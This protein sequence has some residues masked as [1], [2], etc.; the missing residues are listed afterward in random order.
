MRKVS[1]GKLPL[2][3]SP[4]CKETCC[5]A[6]VPS[7]TSATGD[8]SLCT[9]L[10]CTDILVYWFHNIC[11]LC[12]LYSIIKA[13]CL[14]RMAIISCCG[15]N[16]SAMHSS[17][18]QKDWKEQYTE[19][20]Y[21]AK[22]KQ[23]MSVIQAWSQMLLHMWSTS[24]KN[25]SSFHLAKKSFIQ[26]LYICFGCIWVPIPLNEVCSFETSWKKSRQFLWIIV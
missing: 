9:D 25:A 3:Y 10:G 22:I 20:F 8:G 19:L 15:I 21:S 11:R 14:W 16:H 4:Y 23:Q 2:L 7:A 24:Y 17:V 1:G 18:F 13:A 6:V 5:S 12:W 26:F